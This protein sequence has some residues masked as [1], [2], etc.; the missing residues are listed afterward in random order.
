MLHN[1]TGI[2]DH[3]VSHLEDYV[4]DGVEPGGFLSAVLENN[5]V[6]AYS[7]A[8][9]ENARAMEHW[10]RVLYNQVPMAAWSSKDKV[11]KWCAD[12]GYNGLLGKPFG[13]RVP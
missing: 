9:D 10:A 12:G 11:S 8:D 4:W 5:L 3:M 1:L 6:Q 7:R 2:P 13:N